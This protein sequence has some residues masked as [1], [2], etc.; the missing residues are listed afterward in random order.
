MKEPCLKSVRV[1]RGHIRNK[2][3]VGRMMSQSISSSPLNRMGQ[4]HSLKSSVLCWLRRT[5]TEAYHI[6]GTHATIK[7]IRSV[8]CYTD[9]NDV[10]Q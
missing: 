1:I 10:V 9:T 8:L 3:G 7:F 5:D 4:R 6:C 2:V